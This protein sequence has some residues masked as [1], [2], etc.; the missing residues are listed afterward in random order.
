ME[1]ERKSQT[2]ADSS[3]MVSSKTSSL[4]ASLPGQQSEMFDPRL[5]TLDT[6]R[7]GNPRYKTEICRNFKERS[8]C[9][10]G[11]K[12]QFAHG[13]REL[14]DVVRNSKYKTKLCQK[15]WLVGYCAYG[16]RCNFLHDETNETDMIMEWNSMA[17]QTI[18][19]MSS[20]PTTPTNLLEVN[21]EGEEFM[22]LSKV[23]KILISHTPCLYLLLSGIFV[24][25]LKMICK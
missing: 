23:V 2:S 20:R 17:D 12:C 11:D 13:R 25:F 19:T 14:R 10:Y 1:E 16:P 7:L 6:D 9:I 24:G 5:Q 21:R 8:K 18:L 3:E 15:Y 4:F 22:T